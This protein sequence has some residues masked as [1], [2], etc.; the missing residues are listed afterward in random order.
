VNAESLHQGR[1][2]PQGIRDRESAVWKLTQHERKPWQQFWAD[3][4]DLVKNAS[5]AGT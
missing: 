2:L 5:K 4:D 1:A 3:V